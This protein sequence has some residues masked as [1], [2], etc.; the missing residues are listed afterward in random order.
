LLGVDFDLFQGGLYRSFVSFLAGG[1]S[2][3]G[4]DLFFFGMLY[5]SN[6]AVVHSPGSS[7]PSP[8]PLWKH[9]LAEN[10]I[11]YTP[12]C[13]GLPGALLPFFRFFLNFLRT[14]A[15]TCSPPCSRSRRGARFSHKNFVVPQFFIKKP[16]RKLFFF[17]A[18]FNFFR[19]QDRVVKHQTFTFPRS[20]RDFFT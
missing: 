7:F 19:R 3:G 6:H 13:C 16:L 9:S 11:T 18:I 17:F 20:G 5:R 14:K 10:L 1:F 2:P 15:K 4:L 12:P 8:A